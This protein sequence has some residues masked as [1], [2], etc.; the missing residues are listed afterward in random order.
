MLTRVGGPDLDYGCYTGDCTFTQ[1]ATNAGPHVL[2]GTIEV[3]GWFTVVVYQQTAGTL[4]A[5]VGLEL[6]PAP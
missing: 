2:T 1:S 3:T 5:T 4:T 6:V